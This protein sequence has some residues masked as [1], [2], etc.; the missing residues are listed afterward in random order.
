MLS[1]SIKQAEK[2]LSAPE[3]GRVIN[4]KGKVIFKAEFVDFLC[5]TLFVAN[6]DKGK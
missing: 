2:G 4:E 1:R 3:S 5:K 6:Q